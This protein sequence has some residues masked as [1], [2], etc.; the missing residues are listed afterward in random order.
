[1]AVSPSAPVP[2]LHKRSIVRRWQLWLGLAVVLGYGL[3]VIMHWDDRGL[4]WLKEGM[5]SKA[6]R[7]ESVWLPDYVADIEARVLPGM[8]DDEPSDL[9]FNPLTRTLFAVMGN[10]PFLVE[11]NLDGEVLRKMPLVGWDN[12]EGVAVL[13]N[14]QL[15][16]VDERKHDLTLVTVDA[17]TASLNH[18]DYP[19]YDLGKSANKNKGFEAIAWDPAHQRLLIGEERPPKLYT[20]ATDGKSPLTGDKQALP[21]DELDLRN[22]SALGVDPRTG[23]VLVLSADSNMLLELDEKGEQVSFMTLLG[24]FNGLERT[25]PRAEGV[26]MDDQGTLYMVSEPDLFYRFRKN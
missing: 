25:I 12:P 19:H 11:L 23:H 22:L 18:A 16:I 5:E 14:G 26:A 7:V 17:H 21:S 24:G 10:N 2:P 3:S 1:M 9:A 8:S 6:E 4:L 13:A 20:W 15:A